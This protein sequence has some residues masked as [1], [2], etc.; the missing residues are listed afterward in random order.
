MQE[1]NVFLVFTEPLD[2]LGIPYMVTG[3]VASIFYGEP[4]LTHDIDLVLELHR[5]Q[6]KAF[7]DAFP[8]DRFYCP[9]EE[10]VLAELARQARG[11][12]NLIHHESGFKG[13][14][15]LIGNDPLHK[16]AMDNRRRIEFGTSSL[17]LAPPEYVILRKLEYF[18]EGGSEKHTRDIESMLELVLPDLDISFIE[19]H[20]RERGLELVWQRIKWVE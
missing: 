14:M 2:A 4:R 16:W 20:V 13:D 3:S 6:V 7:S 5:H 18:D 11:H 15:Y 9:P 10:V 1:V 12:F 17:W 8:L 19:S